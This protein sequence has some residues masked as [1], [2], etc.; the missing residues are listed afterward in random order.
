M[1]WPCRWAAELNLV[2]RHLGAQE[3]RRGLTTPG[4]R[5]NE[6][7]APIATVATS[8]CLSGS[9]GLLRRRS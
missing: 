2:R 3:V 8:P 7:A 6:T 5:A 4:S 1:S 9:R